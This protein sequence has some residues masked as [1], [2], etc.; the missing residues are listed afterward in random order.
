MSRNTQPTE[1]A[2]ED[3]GIAMNSNPSDSDLVSGC[4][5]A[6]QMLKQYHP[7]SEERCI[8]TLNNM[9]AWTKSTARAAGLGEILD[10]AEQVW[11]DRGIIKRAQKEVK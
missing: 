3:L 9:S 6:I 2:I 7:G 11:V 10:E 1:R 8:S 5:C 4:V